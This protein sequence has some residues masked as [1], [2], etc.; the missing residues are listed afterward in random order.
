[1]IKGKTPKEWKKWSTHDEPS[2]EGSYDRATAR[3]MQEID[4][5]DLLEVEDRDDLIKLIRNSSM[6]N[7]DNLV[8][9]VK[10]K[11]DEPIKRGEWN[12]FTLK[13]AIETI[14][15]NYIDKH[16]EALE[17]IEEDMLAVEALP[18]SDLPEWRA[19]RNEFWREK[20]LTLTREEADYAGLFRKRKPS[21]YLKKFYG[22]SAK[23]AEEKLNE[24]KE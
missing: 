16:P 5:E 8:N 10:F 19:E 13:E 11:W 15:N 24:L 20:G 21:E 4:E 17:R 7:S 3:I 6:D 9:V 18:K 1:M 12:G 23:E 14:K 2:R 22:L